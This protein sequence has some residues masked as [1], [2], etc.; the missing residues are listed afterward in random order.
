MLGGHRRRRGRGRGR[1]IR[2]FLEPCLLLVLRSGAGHGYELK[3]ELEPF[4]LGEVNPS[5]I[6]RALRDMEDDEL[7]ESEW[8]TET[9]AG[10][11]RRVYRLTAAGRARLHQWADDLRA[12]DRMLH[13]FLESVE[14][15]QE[16]GKA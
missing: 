9:T 1:S 6:Y 7:V 4:G 8:D 5:L 2:G 13:H 16:G 11:A 15:P 3:G 10:P 12:T 14:E